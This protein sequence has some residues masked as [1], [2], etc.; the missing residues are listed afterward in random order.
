MLLVGAAFNDRQ[1]ANRLMYHVHGIDWRLGFSNAHRLDCNRAAGGSRRSCFGEQ[2]FCHCCVQDHRTIELWRSGFHR[3][4]GNGGIYCKLCRGVLTK[5][6]RVLADEG[7][8]SVLKYHLADPVIV[9]VCTIEALGILEYVVIAFG[10]DFGVMSGYCRIIYAQDVV[11][12]PA[13]CDCAGAEKN[14]L[15]NTV[16]KLEIQLCHFRLPNAQSAETRGTSTCFYW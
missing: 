8:V 9:H 5:F 3:L 2:F 11:W 6:D 15:D 1:R 16:F 14:L 10:V 13:N 4:A 7:L 12:L